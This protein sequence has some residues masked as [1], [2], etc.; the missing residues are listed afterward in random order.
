MTLRGATAVSEQS[1]GGVQCEPL[2][3]ALPA[4]ASLQRQ[5]LRLAFLSPL[6]LAIMGQLSKSFVMQHVLPSFPRQIEGCE[7]DLR[8]EKRCSRMSLPFG[9]GFLDAGLLRRGYRRADADGKPA[10][11][12][13][14]TP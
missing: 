1:E 4:T 3:P 12:R 11:S 13:L 5:A 7:R 14:A 8:T 2:P 9:S 6:L 10:R